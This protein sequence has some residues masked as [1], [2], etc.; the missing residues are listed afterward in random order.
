MCKALF[1]Q[2]PASWLSPRNR[3]AIYSS[4]VESSFELIRAGTGKWT[5]AALSESMHT[6]SALGNRV[7]LV[8]ELNGACKK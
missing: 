6:G 7:L 4:S 8:L 3:Y 2:R 1:Y 5:E